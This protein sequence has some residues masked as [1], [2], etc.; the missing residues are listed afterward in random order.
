MNTGLLIIGEF[1]PHITGRL[2]Y[3]YTRHNIFILAVSSRLSQLGLVGGDSCTCSGGRE[4]ASATTF[5]CP[6]KMPDV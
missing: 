1:P 5:C 6:A 4:R 3:I 2:L